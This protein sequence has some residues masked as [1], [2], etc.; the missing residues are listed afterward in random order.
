MTNRHVF[1]AQTPQPPQLKAGDLIRNV[2]TGD[3]I[4]IVLEVSEWRKS[5][6]LSYMEVRSVRYGKT[7]GDNFLLLNGQ[8]SRQIR[9]YQR[10]AYGNWQVVDEYVAADNKELRAEI[11]N[12]MKDVNTAYGK[13][14]VDDQGS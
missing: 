7:N 1:C 14:P 11:V 4:N 2:Q 8:R 13:E 9:Y 12:R 5:D 3:L 6:K 10:P